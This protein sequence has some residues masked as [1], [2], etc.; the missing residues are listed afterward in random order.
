MVSNL[1]T[2]SYHKILSSPLPSIEYE[3]KQVWRERQIASANGRYL[4]VRFYI[5]FVGWTAI[6]VEKKNENLWLF[7]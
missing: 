7:K 2:K 6:I 1:I 3:Y 5:L 4:C